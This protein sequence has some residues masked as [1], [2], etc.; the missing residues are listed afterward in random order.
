MLVLAQRGSSCVGV[1]LSSGALVR[2]TCPSGAPLLPFDVA[3]GAIADDPDRDELALPESVVLS[4][5]PRPV[6]RMTRRRAER[7]LR[8]LLHP[9]HRPLL[10]FSGPAAPFWA[11]RRDRPSAAL[12]HVEAGPQVVATAGGLRCRF[13][14]HGCI[15]DLPVEPGRLAAARIARGRD[16]RLLVVLGPPRDGYCYKLVAAI[17]PTP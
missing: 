3:V 13:P 4:S 9:R 12:V 1:D 16:A 7:Y 8:P 15:D 17:L 6:G 14:W 10:G 11:L 2:A 5:P